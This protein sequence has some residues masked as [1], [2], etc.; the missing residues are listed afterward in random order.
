[1]GWQQRRSQAARAICTDEEL[2]HIAAM[3]NKLVDL[4]CWTEAQEQELFED[5]T[6]RC[7]EAVA[8]VLTPPFYDMLRCRSMGLEEGESTQSLQRSLVAVCLKTCDFPYLDEQDKRRV[9]RAVTQVLVG[10]MKRGQEMASFARC[11]NTEEAGHDIVVEVFMAGA[12]D[13]V[14]DEETRHKMVQDMA[15]WIKNV[16][17]IP[18]SM[19]EV[20]CER[21]IRSFSTVLS[22]A[23]H[24]AYYEYKEALREGREL[25]HLPPAMQHDADESDR[26]LRLYEGRPFMLQLRR[27]FITR[28]MDGASGDGQLPFLP[29]SW[30]VL[31]LTVFVD[32]MF[33][34]MPGIEKIEHSVQPFHCSE[35]G[36]HHNHAPFAPPTAWYGEPRTSR[37][38][39]P[40]FVGRWLVP[41]TVGCPSVRWRMPQREDPP[42]AVGAP[43]RA[44]NS[45]PH[46]GSAGEARPG[47]GAAA[48]AGEEEERR[49]REQRRRE[50][51]QEELLG[52]RRQVAQLRGLVADFAA[53][54]RQRLEQELL[55]AAPGLLVSKDAPGGCSCGGHGVVSPSGSRSPER[56]HPP[57]F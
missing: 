56:R 21:I 7:I 5:A 4:P 16:P 34:S 2:H 1:M 57:S 9:V 51:E 18:V 23:L 49:R 19:L 30:Q 37:P 28:I 39:L 13:V 27:T 41:S 46:D 40:A 38:R 12:M 45:D 55:P 26:V 20:I 3:I 32:A 15:V 36:H 11:V 48:L 31:A 29:S 6:M 54:E 52:L 47:A 53:L 42:V 43:G 8:T 24:I 10:A 25:P 35:D 14:F 22:E 50:E 17:L 33:A 44:P